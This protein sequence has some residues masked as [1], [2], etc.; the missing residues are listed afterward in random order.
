MKTQSDLDINGKLEYAENYLI[1][2]DSYSE[3]ETKEIKR[4]FAI[5]KSE[6]KR[7]WLAVKSRIELFE[8][9]NEHWLNGA[10]DIPKKH[11]NA[12]RPE[13]SFED[14]S[15]RSKRRKTEELRKSDSPNKIIYAAQMELRAT[16]QRHASNILKEISE[17]QDRAHEYVKAV[18]CPK[19]IQPQICPEEALKM[20]VKANLTA[21]QYEIIRETTGNLPCYSVLQKHKKACYPPQESLHVTE[22]CAEV[23][24]QAVIDHTAE[25]LLKHL[26]EVLNTL[27]DDERKTLNMICKWGCDGSQQAQYKQKFESD[28]ASDSHIFLSSFVPLRI[29]YGNNKILWQNPTPSS[30]HYCRPIRVRFVKETA[31][32]TNDEIQYIENAANNLKPTTVTLGSR[33]YEMKCNM[34]LTMVDGKV[35]NAATG[36]KSTLRCYICGATSK[37]FNDISVSRPVKKETLRFGLSILHARIRLFETLLH[38]AYK[39]PVKDLPA[40][41]DSDKLLI[42][43]NKERIQDEFKRKLGLRVDF[44]KSGFGN[45]NDGNTS[46]RFFDDPELAAEITGI[47]ATLIKR[48]KIILECISSGFKIHKERFDIYARD[49]AELYIKLYNR[50]PMTPTLHKILIHGSEVVEN[51][52]LPIGQLSEEAAEA[53]NKHFRQYRQNF[54][55]KFSRIDCNTDVI[56]RLL[57]TSDPLISADRKIV[58]KNKKP[59]MP[60]TLELLICEDENDST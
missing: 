38:I 45:S 52:L 10:F 29:T 25:R 4:K 36:T 13:K 12:G 9:N 24:L 6:I 54:A 51:A 14:A 20:F 48:F 7:R 50:H 5:V 49:T 37:E 60:E 39:I 1:S 59:F 53:R 56:Q 15:E 41:S 34:L 18:K 58:K 26:E 30:S 47:D 31:D 21:T 57:L 33:D 44:P 55:R 28:D 23:E 27:K 46:R 19:T 32:V 17:N 42:Q 3:D 22:D 2:L 40:K 43:E 35:C 16:G 8:K 11:L